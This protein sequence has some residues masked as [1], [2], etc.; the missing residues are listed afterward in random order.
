MDWLFAF[1]D[2]TGRIEFDGF[3]PV[4]MFELASG[5]AEAV[6][7]II[8]DT[9]TSRNQK[10]FVPGMSEAKSLADKIGA[11]NKYCNLLCAFNS[12]YFNAKVPNPFNHSVYSLVRGSE[13]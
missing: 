3:V 4:C 8:G 12:F 11:K 2:S 13:K 10:L 7:E 1:C 6:K 9:A 5:S